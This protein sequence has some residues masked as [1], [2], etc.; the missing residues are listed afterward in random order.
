MHSLWHDCIPNESSPKASH[1]GQLREDHRRGHSWHPKPGAW[2][3]H[4]GKWGY[5][6]ITVVV[7]HGRASGAL[8][9]GMQHANEKGECAP[10]NCEHYRTR[11]HWPSSA[12]NVC[13]RLH[14][15]E[16]A[17]RRVFNACSCKRLQAAA[18]TAARPLACK[19]SPLPVARVGSARGD[20]LQSGTKSSLQRSRRLWLRVANPPAPKR[21]RGPPETPFFVGIKMNGGETRA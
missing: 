17:C 3:N 20:R 11:R 2:A 4:R 14:R 12:C 18:C 5:R 7:A 1:A 9:G 21:A 19:R 10:G 15:L 16:T 8:S 13:S 6:P